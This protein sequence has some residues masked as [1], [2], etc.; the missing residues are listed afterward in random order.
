MI[1]NIQVG[2][3]GHYTCTAQTIVDN[4]TAVADVVVKGSS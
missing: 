4:A 3:A 2:H 1:K